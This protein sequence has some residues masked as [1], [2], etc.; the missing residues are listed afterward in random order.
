MWH[1]WMAVTILAA[2]RVGEA[3]NP[4]PGTWDT[5][6]LDFQMGES[7]LAMVDMDWGADH[8]PPAPHVSGFVAMRRCAGARQ[9]MV[10]TTRTLGTGYYRD[11]LAAAAGSEPPQ[12][13]NGAAIRLQLDLAALL[14]E[15]LGPLAASE[16]E[17]TVQ[18]SMPGVGERTHCR[19]KARSH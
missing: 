19:N 12:S 10:F 18:P 5:P 15:P 11:E 13:W 9:G 17:C 2:V 8:G 14:P 7:D 4:G 16:G 1:G 6:E 3:S